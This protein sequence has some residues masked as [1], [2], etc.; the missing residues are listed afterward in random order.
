MATALPAAL[1]ATDAFA[2]RTASVDIFVDL[3]VQDGC[4]ING[5]TSS[6]STLSFGTIQ[7]PGTLAVN[8]TA[9][10]QPINVVCNV[11]STTATFQIDNG[12]NDSAGIHRLASPTP[13][14]GGPRFI[15]YHVYARPND[16]SSEYLIGTP[17]PIGGGVLGGP[18]P[19]AITAGVPFNII[20]HGTILN[21]DAVG[22]RA[23]I[24]SDTLR[25]VLTF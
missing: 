17:I 24:Y 21:A 9:Q 11:D 3:T 5:D 22:A 8:I 1:F 6:N 10:G 18:L 13:L 14:G 23:D 16:P 25:G 4:V 19:G 2:Q 20:L 7:N 12:N 15:N